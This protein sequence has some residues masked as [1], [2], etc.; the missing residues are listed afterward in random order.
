MAHVSLAVLALLLALLDVTVASHGRWLIDL[1]LA[2]AGWVTV[3]GRVSLLL[4]RLFLVGLCRDLVDPGSDGFH[5]AFLICSGVA[6]LPLRQ[7]LFQ[8]QAS[9]WFAWTAVLVLAERLVVPVAG[10]PAAHLAWSAAVA[11]GAA[12]A[13]GGWLVDGLPGGLHPLGPQRA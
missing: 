10:G 4:P 13:I 12:A 5:A 1:P 9:V 8:H 6:F 7:A 3:A 2:L 11:T